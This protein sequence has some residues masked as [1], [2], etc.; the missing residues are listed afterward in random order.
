MIMSPTST[1]TKALSQTK[2]LAISVLAVISKI[3]NL[4]ADKVKPE[5]RN[6]VRIINKLA[7]ETG[8]M[9]YGIGSLFYHLVHSKPLIYGVAF[10]GT[11]LL[12]L[13]LINKA[14][15]PKIAAFSMLSIHCFS[16]IYFGALLGMAISTELVVFFLVVFLVLGS[17]FIFRDYKVLAFNLVVTV[18]LT[19]VIEYNNYHRIIV[20][21]E[22]NH[23]N[24]FIFRWFSI[25]GMM[26]LTLTVSWDFV[27]KFKEL[28]NRLVE[29]ES[30]RRTY[31][32][33]TSHELKSPLNTILTHAS[34]IKSEIEKAG[35]SKDQMLAISKSIDS[36]MDSSTHG[37]KVVNNVQ[38]VSKIESGKPSNI[39]LTS[40]KVVDLFKKLQ[41]TYQLT[42][43]N[44]SQK[45][46][47]LYT[48]NRVPQRITTDE[49][50]L[51]QIL[52]NLISNAL[53]YGPFE[54]TVTVSID[55]T[56]GNFIVRIHNEGDPIPEATKME[57]FDSY[58]SSDYTIG[59]GA[60]LGL[61]ISAN[62]AK[63]LGGEIK[64]SCDELP[65]GITF[66][67][68]IPVQINERLSPSESQ[69]ITFNEKISLFKN[70]KV[71]AIDDDT[72]MRTALQLLFSESDFH[73]ALTGIEGLK[74]AEDLLPD[75][76]LLDAVMAGEIGGK[77]TLIRLKSNNNLKHIPVI[78]VTG[79][80]FKETESEYL[81]AGAA[82][83]LTKPIAAKS[84]QALCEKVENNSI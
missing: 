52:L 45:I 23:Y 26:V 38:E 1:V 12:A 58:V 79:N 32:A 6:S 9:V 28:L 5:E 50:M 69:F 33:E 43:E 66:V 14:G 37:I 15:K 70:K 29:N 11:A 47:I 67:V 53:K 8:L 7:L 51:R 59:G 17:F 39:V 10:E 71:L 83:F 73:H 13:L 78:M 64:V 84:L 54:S 76:I 61:R 48:K 49:T 77:E 4:G 46:V 20:P 18:A 2:K 44:K 25:G 35:A 56:A 65:P 57:I 60:G 68:Q 19:V 72:V 36:I 62:L 31:L 80:Y 3:I 55:Y 30:N 82:Y 63:R 75:L 24:L 16:A 40:F 81:A 42:A 41:H 34:F 22:L 74:I 27:D 21:I